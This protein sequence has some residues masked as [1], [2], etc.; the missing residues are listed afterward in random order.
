MK[1]RLLVVAVL[2]VAVFSLTACGQKEGPCENCGKVRP[3]YEFTVEGEISLLGSSVSESEE[4]IICEECLD[5]TIEQFEQYES[6]L[7]GIMS[8]DY[9]KL[10]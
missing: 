2:I 6:L 7:G 3:L 5:E 10:R 4:Y 8:Y 1:K 9:K